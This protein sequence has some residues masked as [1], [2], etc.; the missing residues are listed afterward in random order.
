MKDDAICFLLLCVFVLLLA[1]LVC[2]L[3]PGAVALIG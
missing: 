1:A 2:V 3:A